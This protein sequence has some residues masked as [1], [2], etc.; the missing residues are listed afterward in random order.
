M[1]I[2]PFNILTFVGDDNNWHIRLENTQ[3]EGMRSPEISGIIPHLS[4][5]W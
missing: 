5:R 1:R 4:N 3:T 2:I